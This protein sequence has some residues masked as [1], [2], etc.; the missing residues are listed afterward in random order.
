MVE[1]ISSELAFV[2]RS[3]LFKTTTIPHSSN[4][5]HQDLTLQPQSTQNIA[6]CLPT[7]QAWKVAWTE[8]E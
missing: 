6:A 5:S 4:S 7:C 2:Y 8:I 3:S 1:R